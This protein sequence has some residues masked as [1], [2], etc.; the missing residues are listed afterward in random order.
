VGGRLVSCEGL[1]GRGRLRV[2]GVLGTTRRGRVGA[3]E[4]RWR[5]KGG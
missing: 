4:G 3:G 5:G 2:G 1:G